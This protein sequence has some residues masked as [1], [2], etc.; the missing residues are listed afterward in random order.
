MGAGLGK[1]AAGLVASCR[2][3]AFSGK[4]VDNNG[5]PGRLD[6]A[7]SAN[8]T[9]RSCVR[10]SSFAMEVVVRHAAGAGVGPCA[11]AA[12]P[13][14]LGPRSLDQ[15][16]DCLARWTSNA[17]IDGVAPRRSQRLRTAGCPS[18]LLASRLDE[19]L[20]LRRG[21]GAGGPPRVWIATT[22]SRAA[23][24]YK[25]GNVRPRTVRSHDLAPP[26]GVGGQSMTD[27]GTRTETPPQLTFTRS[28]PTPVAGV[29]VLR[30]PRR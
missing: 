29:V 21:R 1:A 9:S 26:C 25:T 19:H 12:D 6:V 15:L 2:W 16:N 20:R 27:T 30:G 11:V 14:L 13:S 3:A 4:Y 22:S 24:T 28:W 17:R 23:R 8:M 10:R 18:D 7:A 5:E